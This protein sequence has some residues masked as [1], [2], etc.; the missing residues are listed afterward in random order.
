MSETWGKWTL[1]WKDILLCE[2]RRG[3]GEMRF[4][5]VG[6]T[7]PGSIRR[8]SGLIGEPAVARSNLT[9]APWTQWSNQLG[10]KI[11]ILYGHPPRRWQLRMN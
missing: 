3:Y 5:G 2:M 6:R 4:D 8:G 11:P 7:G 9:Q 10:Q 1:E